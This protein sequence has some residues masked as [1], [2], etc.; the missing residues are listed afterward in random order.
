MTGFG[1]H[2]S[3]VFGKEIGRSLGH[4][5]MALVKRNKMENGGSRAE[6]PRLKLHQNGPDD[7]ERHQGFAGLILLLQYLF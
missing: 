5:E 1:L 6:C 7:R 4:V 2:C 3:I